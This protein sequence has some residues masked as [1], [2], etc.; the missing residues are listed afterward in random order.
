MITESI[1]EKSRKKTELIRDPVIS[2]A[3]FHVLEKKPQ[4]KKILDELRS[5]SA[6]IEHLREWALYSFHSLGADEAEE[7]EKRSRMIVGALKKA[8][9]GYRS[10][11]ECYAIYAEEPHYNWPEA[12]TASEQFKQ[13]VEMNEHLSR[14]A[15]SFLK[16]AENTAAYNTKR[17]GVA[18]NCA[19]LYLL[20]LYIAK[21]T[22]WDDPHI[23]EAITYL[24]TAAHESVRQRVPANVR[25]LL[26]KAIRK[27]ENDPRN[28]TILERLRKVA[29]DSRIL[30]KMF[31]IA[32]DTSGA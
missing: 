13:L 6:E 27:F 10:A 9:V 12:I 22:C 24:I 20:K 26:R 17:L 2:A 31:P 8:I 21:L 18:W 14:Q 30:Y 5:A 25:V 4:A 32:G 23:L 11:K 15:E 16:R 1:R 29:S 7:K 28:A 19:Y 3:F